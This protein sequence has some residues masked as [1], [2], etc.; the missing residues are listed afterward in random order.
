MWCFQW[1]V[2][3]STV[4]AHR[5]QQAL[6]H[7]TTCIVTVQSL[8]AYLCQSSM[9]RNQIP[10]HIQLHS[11]IQ[12]W[13]QHPHILLKHEY[14]MCPWSTYKP[15]FNG[16]IWLWKV[17]NSG[18]LDF[19]MRLLYLWMTTEESCHKFCHLLIAAVDPDSDVVI[20]MKQGLSPKWWH[21]Y[22][23][24]VFWDDVGELLLQAAYRN[25]P[26]R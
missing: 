24:S 2:A 16:A 4:T 3:W 13:G 12:T 25:P 23:T 26:P 14:L 10:S 18:I 19:Y 5:N 20:V 8:V 9:C 11:C 17:Y 7:N 15:A 1:T 6:C 22:S 21:L